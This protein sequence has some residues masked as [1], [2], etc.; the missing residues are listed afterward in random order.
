MNDNCSGGCNKCACPMKVNAPT[1]CT[2]RRTEVF[3]PKEHGTELSLDMLNDKEQ[4]FLSYL[5]AHQ[6]LPVVQFVM[7]SSENPVFRKVSL[8]PAY[9]EDVSDSFEKIQ[10]MGTMLDKLESDGFIT[11]DF[12]IPL[13]NCDYTEYYNSD[14]FAFYKNMISEISS[15]QV[16]FMGDTAT[17]EKGSMAATAACTE[18]FDD[19]I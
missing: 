2:V 1:A 12:D 9:I 5:V 17:I 3:T 11:L 16:A 8:S 18:L 13:Q 6:Y 10:M 7:L 4:I 15:N 19:I 14:I